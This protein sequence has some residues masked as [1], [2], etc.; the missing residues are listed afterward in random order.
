[1]Y[2]WPLIIM[3]TLDEEEEEEVTGVGEGAGEGEGEGAREEEAT[4]ADEEVGGK[5]QGKAAQ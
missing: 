1:M 5:H 4:W 3:G 2:C